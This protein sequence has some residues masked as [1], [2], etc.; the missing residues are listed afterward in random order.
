MADVNDW[1]SG[2]DLRLWRR[3]YKQISQRTGHGDYDRIRIEKKMFLHVAHCPLW[4]HLFASV[5]FA[6]DFVVLDTSVI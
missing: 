4:K 5:L 1:Q 6:D 2:A 3:S